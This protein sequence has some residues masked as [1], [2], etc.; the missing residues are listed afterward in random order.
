MRRML[1]KIMDC[2]GR[3]L[4]ICHDGRTQKVQA[5]LQ[6]LTGRG[7]N[8]SKM[9]PSPLGWEEKGMFVYIGPVG[10]AMSEGDLLTCPE[11]EFLFRRCET[12]E[13][14]G[15]PAYRWGICV[16]KGAEDRWGMNG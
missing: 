13:G 11:G 9:I 10:A 7:E 3:E 15:G 5:F 12:V 4:E 8:L 16:R 1:E 2:Y 6:P 14:I